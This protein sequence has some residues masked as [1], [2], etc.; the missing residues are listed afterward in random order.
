MRKVRPSVSRGEIDAQLAVLTDRSAS[1]IA[2]LSVLTEL[3]TS[4][5]V[6]GAAQDQRVIAA[7]SPLMFIDPAEASGSRD[8]L[9]EEMRAHAFSL[10]KVM[11]ESNQH[12]TCFEGVHQF[13]VHLL[14]QSHSDSWPNALKILIIIYAKST[15]KSRPALCCVAP[16]LINYCVKWLQ[17]L[18][19]AIARASDSAAVPPSPMAATPR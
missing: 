5:H 13:C 16:P 9:Q 2:K 10:L 11:V 6:R 18:H 12:E 8:E 17:D 1:A 15:A 14:E 7:L 4:D 19:R 3:N